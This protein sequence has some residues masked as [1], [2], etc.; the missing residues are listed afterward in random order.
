VNERIVQCV[1]AAIDE[2]NLQRDG[3]SP[4]MEKAL[5]TPIHGT[6]SALDS[7]G[8]INFVLAVEENVTRSFGVPIVLGD[9]R[10]LS[11]ELSPFRSV[12]ALAGYIEDL[13]EERKEP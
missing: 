9:D 1:Y 8:L 3:D 4:P 5:A 6:A 2:E 11:Q 7:L 12:E 13:L 10:A